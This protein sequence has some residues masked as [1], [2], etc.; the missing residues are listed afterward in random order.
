MLKA[1][2]NRYVITQFECVD[3]FLPL[4]LVIGH[5]YKCDGTGVL[6]HFIL[7]HLQPYLIHN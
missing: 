6:V 3:V 4:P 5:Q 7:F 1:K 2:K